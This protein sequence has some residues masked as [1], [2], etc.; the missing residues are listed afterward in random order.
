MIRIDLNVPQS[1]GELSQLQLEQLLRILSTVGGLSA[2]QSVMTQVA[3]YC[4]MKWNNISSLC[5]VSNGWLIRIGNVSGTISS[6]LLAAL[7][8]SMSW[9][10]ESPN[11]PVRIDSIDGCRAAAADLDDDTDFD[12]WLSC[13]TL[14]Q[15]YQLNSN[16][17]LLRRMSQLLYKGVKEFREWQL[18]GVFFWWAGIKALCNELYPN[19]F[20]PVEVQSSMSNESFRRGIDAQIRALTKGDITKEEKVLA[21]PCHRA[22]TELDALAREYEELKRKYMKK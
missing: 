17:E 7:T 12:T 10:R 9:L 18:I 6:E 19:F 13:E 20:R 8:E 2:G 4:V 1:W 11:Q 3:L 5:P 14:W 21:M 15:Q 22:L 16:I